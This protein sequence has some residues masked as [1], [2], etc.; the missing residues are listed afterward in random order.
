MKNMGMLEGPGHGE[1]KQQGV[2]IEEA[3][4]GPPVRKSAAL[5]A[6]L[7]ARTTSAAVPSLMCLSHPA[8]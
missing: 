8:I 1:H 3:G 2:P 6:S 4:T 7:A 5:C